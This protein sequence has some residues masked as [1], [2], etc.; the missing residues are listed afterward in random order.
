MSLH[1]ATRDLHH[2]CEQHPV[3]QRMVNGAITAQEWADWL[4]AFR[5]LHIVVDATLPW[6]MNR[7]VALTTDLAT[8]PPANPS[9][10]AMRFA[11]SL[12]G[13]DTTGAAYVLHG[14]HRSGGRVLAPKMAKRGFPTAHTCYLYPDVV[15]DWI[16]EA[17]G[18]SAFAEQARDTFGCLLAVMDEIGALAAALAPVTRA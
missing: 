17:R 10:A 1:E 4:W 18:K 3:G 15:Q 6:H 2:A 9:P 8:L 12:M 16:S 7:L 5:A 13:K 11:A 14:A